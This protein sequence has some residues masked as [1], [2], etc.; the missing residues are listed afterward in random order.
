MPHTVSRGGWAGAPGELVKGCSRRRC[1]SPFREVLALQRQGEVH[2]VDVGRWQGMSK[3]RGT[4]PRSTQ[5]H[6]V[7]WMK[8]WN[9]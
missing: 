8:R 4:P 9:R 2:A 7:W 6:R 5:Q 1:S 3:V